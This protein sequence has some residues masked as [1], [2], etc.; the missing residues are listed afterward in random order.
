MENTLQLG[1]ET[2]ADLNQRFERLLA[3]LTGA[4][5]YLLKHQSEPEV[6]VESTN[7]DDDDDIATDPESAEIESDSANTITLV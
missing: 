3:K 5:T 2:M 7:D 4:I 1:T 6:E